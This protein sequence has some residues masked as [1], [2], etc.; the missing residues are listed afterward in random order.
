MD[1]GKRFVSLLLLLNLVS[2]HTSLWAE[3][4]AL[5]PDPYDS[6]EFPLWARDLRR[7]E[8]V[9]FG[10]LPFTIFFATL[11]VDSYRYATH[12]WD[13]LYA[14]WPLKPAGAIEMSEQNKGLVLQAGIASAA[15]L[16]VLDYFIVRMKRE[17]QR[18]EESTAPKG[19]VTVER[20]K[21]K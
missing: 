16:A 13:E 12:E 17:G 20:I 19:E 18:K 15:V 9:A 6:E 3:Q 8:I 1:R 2:I 11:A 5:V 21:P 14:P 10:V 7:A 4:K